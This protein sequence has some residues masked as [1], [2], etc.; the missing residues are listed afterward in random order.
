MPGVSCRLRKFPY[1]HAFAEQ[2]PAS[3]YSVEKAAPSAA[4]TGDFAL[5]NRSDSLMQQDF[6]A[7]G[8]WSPQAASALGIAHAAIRLKFCA[9]RT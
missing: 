3:T 9:A 7:R 5:N 1:H 4:V 8:V 2:G 6:L